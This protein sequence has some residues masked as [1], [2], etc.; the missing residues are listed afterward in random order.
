MSDFDDDMNEISL[1]D[2]AG[3]DVS[4][5]AEVRYEVLPQM[6][7]DFEITE[8]AFAESTIKSGDNE[9]HKVFVGKVEMKVLEAKSLLDRV[10]SGQDKAE[11]L[12]GLRDKT[13]SENLRIK[14][15]I[16]VG[17]N[18]QEHQARLAK[19]MGKVRAFVNDVGGEWGANIVEAVENLKGVTFTGKIEHKTDKE[20]KS[21]KWPRL[22]LEKRKG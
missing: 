6:I 15:G 13:Y 20:D 4:D 22:K 10:P 17:E 14:P 3:I 21:V 16:S 19:E 11:Y 8:A 18:A 1:A 12:E 7:A 9:G 5:I 2:L